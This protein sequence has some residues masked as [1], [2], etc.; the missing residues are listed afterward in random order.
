MR[1][2]VVYGLIFLA[3][4]VMQ[5]AATPTISSVTANPTS[6]IKTNKT[7]ITVQ[8]TDPAYPAGPLFYA[9]SV[10]ASPA[11]STVGFL[12]NYIKA[13]P[14]KTVL[15]STATGSTGKYTLKVRVSNPAGQY[16][17]KSIDIQ[18]NLTASSIL[19]YPPSW[20]TNFKGSRTYMAVEFDQFG[21]KMATQPTINWSINPPFLINITSSGKV[22]STANVQGNYIVTA[23]DAATNLTANASFFVV[24]ST[25]MIADAKAKIK[26]VIIIMQE[27]RSF[28]NY[29]GKFTPGN[30]QRIDTIPSDAWVQYNG[31]T[32][33]P[34]TVYYNTTDGNYGHDSANAAYILSN[35]AQLKY[36]DPNKFITSPNT[37]NP[38][39]IFGTHPETDLPAYW[40]LA[41][42]FVLQDRMFE[43][44]PT[45]SK[46]AHLYLY[47]GWSATKVNGVWKTCVGPESKPYD[48][49]YGWN[50]LGKLIWNSS[51][52]WGLFHGVGWTRSASSPCG[53][54]DRA[55][56]NEIDFVDLWGPIKKFD[57]VIAVNN[58]Y[59]RQNVG[60]F[61]YNMSTQG[62]A[63]IPKVSWII[64]NS[65]WSDHGGFCDIKDGHSYVVSIIQ[66][67]MNNSSLWNS[68]AIFLAWDDW[69]GFYDHV[70]PP[71]TDDGFGY[72]LRVPGLTI[73]PFAKN[74]VVDNQPL[75]FDAY[76]RFIEDLYCNGARVPKESAAA[77]QRPSQ[78]END[79]HLGNLLYEF[80]FSR[81]LLPITLPCGY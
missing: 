9:W 15:F 74:N 30:N 42:N 41:R 62:E 12:P 53:S 65:N 4:F 10:T 61:L 75:S 54:F 37:G 23:K 60:Q 50:S 34:G 26:H 8:A 38:D 81:K 19:I 29:F 76:L 14:V 40:Q 63:G 64:P 57:D 1:R 43:P 3:I 70:V 5:V 67:I 72:G 18:V 69:G 11:G 49:T 28:D 7:Q 73:S 13:I 24:D 16:A 45:Y 56:A 68:C 71:T 44:A 78:R 31:T 55:N 46:V 66:Q 20:T 32:Y 25:Q 35:R 22:T 17:E 51:G 2:M 52:N 39:E 59:V 27:N 48:A 58:G 21:K 79:S 77:G 36:L 33:T 47:S 6:P 80:D